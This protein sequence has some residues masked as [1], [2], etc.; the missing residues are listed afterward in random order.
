[1]DG[2]VAGLVVLPDTVQLAEWLPQVWGPET[3]FDDMDEA[4]E[5]EAALLGHYHGVARTPKAAANDAVLPL[6][7]GAYLYDNEAQLET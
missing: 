1:M 4:A 5:L 7:T 3:R 2:F 6:Q